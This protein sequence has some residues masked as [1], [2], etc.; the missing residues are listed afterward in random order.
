MF[1]LFT[2]RVCPL[3]V[4]TYDCDVNVSNIVVSAIEVARNRLKLIV[5]ADVKSVLRHTGFQLVFGLTYILLLAELACD[6]IYYIVAVTVIR[7]MQLIFL[8]SASD[9]DSLG[10]DHVRAVHTI[11]ATGATAPLFGA[12][13]GRTESTPD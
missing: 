3:R 9:F 5:M 8:T 4:V 1:A 12:S 10:L 11:L 2:L 7:T 6:N 13:R